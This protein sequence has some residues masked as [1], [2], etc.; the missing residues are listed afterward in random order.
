MQNLSGKWKCPSDGG[1]YYITLLENNIYINGV[2]SGWNNVGFGTINPDT[3]SIVVSW[4]D[5]P[6]NTPT[7]SHGIE[8]LDASQQDTIVKKAGSCYGYGNLI[9]IT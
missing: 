8:Y 6:N 2:G 5:T 3:S 9:K 7:Q 1:T 4:A